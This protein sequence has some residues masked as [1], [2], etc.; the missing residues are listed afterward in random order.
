[1]LSLQEIFFI[2]YMKFSKWVIDVRLRKMTPIDDGGNDVD[3]ID[4]NFSHVD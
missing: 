3:Y 4:V 2:S 1:M